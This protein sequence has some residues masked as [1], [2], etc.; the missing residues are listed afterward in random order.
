M[1]QHTYQKRFSSA[2]R[3]PAEV[4]S[5]EGL[6]YSN[7]ALAAMTGADSPSG[8]NLSDIHDS[9]M[10]RFS[11]PVRESVQAQIPTASE[12]VIQMKRRGEPASGPKG[13]ESSIISSLESQSGVDLSGV[14]IHRNSPKPAEIGALAYAQG[15]QVY[16]GPGQEA[17]LGH[18]LT[19]VVQQKQGMV[20]ST[21][22]VDGMPVN[23]SPALE[24]AADAMQVSSAPAVSAP[25][26][27]IV[28]GV[29]IDPTGKRH[30]DRDVKG[31]KRML[32]GSLDSM[33]QEI[34][35]SRMSRSEKKRTLKTLSKARKKVGK[36]LK[37]AQKSSQEFSAADEIRAVINDAFSGIKMDSAKD[38]SDMKL[39]FA[40]KFG[41]KKA[42]ETYVQAH[43]LERDTNVGLER[44][45]STFTLPTKA[46]DGIEDIGEY[47]PND[48]MEELTEARMGNSTS[49]AAELATTPE[50]QAKR[51]K[52]MQQF[53]DGA[54]VARQGA[55][56]MK[57][58]ADNISFDSLMNLF[59][60]INTQVRGG[61]KGAGQLRG[62]KVGVGQLA[63]PRAAG[64]SEDAYRTFAMI[65][66]QMKL[67]KANPDKKLA[68]TQAIHL[69]AFA[70]QMTISE[71]MFADGNGRTC[72]LFADSILQTFG[73]P[74]STPVKEL[75][76][77]GGNIGDTFDFN[78]GA[79]AI[80][81]GVRQS[82][83]TLKANRP[84]QP[85]TP[86]PAP[87]AAPAP[88]PAAPSQRQWVSA[89]PAPAAPGAQLVNPSPGP[90]SKTT[91]DTMLYRSD[92]IGQMA[93]APLVDFDPTTSDPE[94]LA[95]FARH[96]YDQIQN[97][98]KEDS[99]EDISKRKQMFA[100]VRARQIED[101]DRAQQRA[102]APPPAPAPA[103]KKHGWFHRKKK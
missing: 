57:E 81:A 30:D 83:Q 13:S 56:A 53:N 94:Q 51:Q 24:H 25:G 60:S 34:N 59:S 67:I 20:R 6:H 63:P 36:R 72:R 102:A 95:L 62:K 58:D 46:A 80:M 21:G 96:L 77:V 76:H 9:I 52:S 85:A 19:H 101:E 14:K 55:A 49:L 22:T 91:K 89:R 23:T 48:A 35:D 17:H 16:L 90:G 10:Q 44:T 75:S 71:H 69:A 39:L 70:Y 41:G 74:P 1:G 93:A 43:P 92:R 18:E 5:P 54:T 98:S 97:P 7:S 42:L 40:D 61:E 28:Q 29:F 37:A 66:N 12:P 2:D 79:D 33:M 88:A 103:K 15:E 47:D 26:P 38:S 100:A 31:M 73:L 32:K 78:A 65:A 64:L 68:K 87:Q 99:E 84:A 11:A 45:M 3:Q 50:A 8:N 86:A 4:S 82:D 27:G